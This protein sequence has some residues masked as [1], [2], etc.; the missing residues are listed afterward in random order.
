MK[1]E[2]TSKKKQTKNTKNKKNNK[3]KK[4]SNRINLSNEIFIGLTPKQDE[5]TK[6]KPSKKVNKKG[7]VKKKTKKPEKK[8]KDKKVKTKKNKANTR[9][10]KIDFENRELNK[11]KVNIAKWTGI[12]ILLI[13]LTV[14][15]L[16]S[17]L[18]NIKEIVV[19]GNN[20]LTQEELINLASIQ[21]ET[22]MFNYSKKEINKKLKENP[23]IESATFKRSVNGIFTLKVNE[24]KP[25]YM[26]KFANAF[27][28]INNQGYMLEISETPI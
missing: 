23:Y 8:V 14:V 6:K 9:R 17:S 27:V 2:N 20:K 25:T 18:F 4:N 7:N 24:R 3:A 16:K 1:K 26:L 21:K 10:R 15:L 5:K 12:V 19:E 28:Y 22:N 13:I 11:V